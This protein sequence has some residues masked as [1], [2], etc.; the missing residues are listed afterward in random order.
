M[1]GYVEDAK[2]KRRPRKELGGDSL[3]TCDLQFELDLVGLQ[4]DVSR[5]LVQGDM[6]SVVLLPMGQIDS[7][8]CRTSDGQ[9]VGALSAFRGLAQLI[10]CIKKGVK[11]EAFVVTASTTRCAVEVARVEQ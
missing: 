3:D 4:P 6:L 2:P 8:V 5:R 1:G 11:Y 10:A 9:I 7:V